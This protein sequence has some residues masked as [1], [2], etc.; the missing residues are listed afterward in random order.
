MKTKL[1]R[2][3]VEVS[4]AVND[5]LT[6]LANSLKVKRSKAIEL[7]IVSAVE[8]AVAADGETTLA[9]IYEK[10]TAIEE[11]LFA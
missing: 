9:M 3:Y 1:K 4:P 7:A 6:D 10:L 8:R 11:R 5:A 2:R